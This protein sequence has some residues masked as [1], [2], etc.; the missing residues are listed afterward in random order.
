MKGILLEGQN[1]KKDYS[2]RFDYFIQVVV[3]AIKGL[4]LFLKRNC[5]KKGI[6]QRRRFLGRRG[7]ILLQKFGTIS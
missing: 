3:K 1:P 4:A 7:V 5:S 6:W 2:R